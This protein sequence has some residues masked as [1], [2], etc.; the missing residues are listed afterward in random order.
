MG[1]PSD[2]QQAGRSG[3]E[4]SGAAGASSPGGP[5]TSKRRVLSV[6]QL[7]TVQR[8]GVQYEFRYVKGMRMPPGAAMIRGT[9]VHKGAEHNYRQ[10]VKSRADLPLDEVVD[11][12]VQSV[13]DSFRGGVLFTPEEASVGPARVRDDTIDVAARL[14]RLHQEK[15]SPTVQPA[16]VERKITM[17]VEPAEMSRDLVGV[18]DMVTEGGHLPDLKTS[19]RVPSQDDVDSDQ[20]LTMGA[21]LYRALTGKEEAGVGLTTLV[22]AAPGKER[23]D[24][25]TSRRDLEDVEVLVRRLKRAAQVIDA[26]V[27]LPT[28]P[29]NWWCSASWCG[30]WPVCPFVRGGRRIA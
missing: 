14:M 2:L 13:R 1:D 16:M 18:L 6:S 4:G 29:R 17:A 5:S 11:A 24:I 27:F 22:P 9:G 12:A 28:N 23:V 21:L 30:Y 10:K 25:K 3:T 20:Q 7:V 26:G 19:S 8:C 15:V